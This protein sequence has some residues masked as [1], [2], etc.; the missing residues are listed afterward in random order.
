MTIVYAV[1]LLGILIFVHELGHF[2]FAKAVGIKV[3]KFSLG[4]GPKLI[5][6]KYGDTE[7]VLSAFLIGGYVKMHGDEMASSADAQD[8]EEKDRAF[9]TQPIYKRA[10]VVVAGSLFNI[11][12]AVLLFS[13]IFLTGVPRYLSVV[14]D[15]GKDTPAMRAGLKP[16]DVIMR[17]GATEIKFWEEMTEIIHESPGKPLDFTIKGADGTSRNITI[18]P[19]SKLSKNIFG[20]ETRMGL[21]GISPSGDSN[22]V[23]YGVFDSI[24]MGFVKTWEVIVLLLLSIVKLFQSVI[25]ANTIGGP[26]MIFQMAAKQSSGGFLSFIMFMAVIS[27]NLGVFNLFPIPILDGGHMVYLAIEALRKKPLSEQA[28]A[29]SQKIGLALLLML[30]AFAMYNDVVRIFTGEKLP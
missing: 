24:V 18:T 13:L 15:V 23:A 9:F 8:I 4:M 30:M 2:I 11:F 21:I 14:G 26:I 17:I 5:G 7:Y 20:E 19:E 22:K 10:I 27:I 25:P 3:T 28:I 6:R 16:G 29:I 1:L 12:F